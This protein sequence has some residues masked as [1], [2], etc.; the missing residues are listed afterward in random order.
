MSF[1][2]AYAH[3][4]RVGA[5]FRCPEWIGEEVFK[6]PEYKR[7]ELGPDYPIR[8]EIDLKPDETNV[9]IR[10]YAQNQSAMIY[11]RKQAREWLKLK[12]SPKYVLTD[13]HNYIERLGGPFAGVVIAHLRRGDYIGYG[14]PLVS[15]KSYH[16]AAVKFGLCQWTEQRTLKPPFFFVSEE[17][18]ITQM[19]L[20]PQLSF[21]PDF[22][23]MIHAPNLFRANSSFSWLAGLLCIGRVFSPIVKGLQGGVEHDVEFVEGNWPALS[24]LAMGTDMHIKEE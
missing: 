9:C 20:P 17:N 2:H 19:G 13:W 22:Y 6:L 4:Q 16:E 7:P 10:G 21:L 23:A 15:V 11:T 12:P 1:L 24:D 8:S 3:A 18:P 14:Y 5:E